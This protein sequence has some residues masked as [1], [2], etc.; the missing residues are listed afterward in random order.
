MDAK[1]LPISYP[2]ITTFT[3]YA[4]TLAILL[5]HKESYDWI[6][7][8]YL[9]IYVVE[10]LNRID[11]RD[12]SAFER[13]LSIPYTACFF[14]DLDNRRLANL[15]DDWFFLQR[16]NCLYLESFEMASEMIDLYEDSFT[17]YIKKM[18]NLS[19]YVFT[20][21]DV[22]KISTY[23]RDTPFS[24][25]V[26]IFGYNDEKREIHYADFINNPI[27]KYT[28]SV[29]S[30]EE[31]DSAY[32]SVKTLFVPGVKSAAAI[33]YNEYPGNYDYKYIR[34][35][36]RE[37]I[38]PDLIKA[39]RFNEFTKSIY[40]WANWETRVHIGIGVYDYLSEFIAVELDAGEEKIDHRLYHAMYDH[41]EMMVQRLNYLLAKGSLDHTKLPQINAYSIVRDNLLIIRNQI[42]KFNATGNSKVKDRVTMLLME[43]KE[44]ETALLK[45]LFDID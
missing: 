17:S 13:Q 29:C 3:G 14:G 32:T 33:R 31:I 39:E 23:G 27:G 2:P 4:A 36:V 25:Q 20:Y 6:Y 21:L 28:F 19:M 8:N 38:Y 11:N 16:G 24:H 34:E 43:T 9:Q 18:I 35:T 44:I 41:K 12:K 40:S 37:Y 22:S 1:I 42:L 26:L 45:Q 30:Y 7:A 10:I 15:V 5:E